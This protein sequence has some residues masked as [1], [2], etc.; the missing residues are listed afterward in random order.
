MKSKINYLSADDWLMPF[1]NSIRFGLFSCEK[2]AGT[3][4]MKNYGPHD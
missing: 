2:K 4:P 3:G 1:P